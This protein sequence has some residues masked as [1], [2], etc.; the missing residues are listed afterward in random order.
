MMEEPLVS[1]IAFNRDEAQLTVA[2]V[3][4]RPGIAAA[5]LGTIGGA[6]IEIDM[7]VQNVGADGS[8][9]FTFTVHRNEFESALEIRRK[10]ATEM[11]AKGVNTATDH[12]KR[13]DEHTAET[14]TRMRIPYD[15][16]S[17]TN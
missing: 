4:D 2:G 10:L 14:H 3:P 13:T 6:N 7:I 15:V 11:G 9:D 8:T 5:I 17:L 1:G 12:V 16:Y